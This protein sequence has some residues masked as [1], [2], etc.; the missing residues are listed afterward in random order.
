M[1]ALPFIITF[2]VQAAM[3]FPR[4]QL[5]FAHHP[6]AFGVFVG[7]ALV[8][9]AGA[10]PWPIA[11]LPVGVLA[12]GFRGVLRARG[13]DA[14]PNPMGFGRQAGVAAFAAFLITF[15]TAFLPWLPSHAISHP[16]TGTFT[17]YVLQVS[18]GSTTVLADELRRI[19]RRDTARTAH[20]IRAKPAATCWPSRRRCSCSRHSRPQSNIPRAPPQLLASPL[21]P[22]DAH[23]VQPSPSTAAI[24]PRL[25]RHTARCPTTPAVELDDGQPQI[26]RRIITIPIPSI[27]DQEQCVHY[28]RTT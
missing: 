5:W 19:I 22:R 25:V 20:Q 11:L 10:I 14:P 16:D 13:H 21:G 28:P 9:Y 6:R 8:L 7:A 23:M 3:I 2:G 24:R 12:S 26:I 27:R 17:G 18:E 15:L 4:P 1:T